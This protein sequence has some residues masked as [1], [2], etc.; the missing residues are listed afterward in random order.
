VNT[1]I[2]LTVLAATATIV[3]SVSTIHL[4]RVRTAVVT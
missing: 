3:V 4:K 2:P 1:P